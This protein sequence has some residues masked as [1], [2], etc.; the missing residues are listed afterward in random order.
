MNSIQRNNPLLK[1][2]ENYSEQDYE[3]EPKHY[4][5]EKEDNINNSSSFKK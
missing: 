3:E 5:N 2:G 1:K 4:E